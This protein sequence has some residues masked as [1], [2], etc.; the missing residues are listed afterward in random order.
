[1][2]KPHEAFDEKIIE[3]AVDEVMAQYAGVI[4]PAKQEEIRRSLRFGLRTNPHAPLLLR[5]LRP[6]GDVKES[7]TEPILGTAEAPDNVVKGKEGAR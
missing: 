2:T 6:R 1:M 7:G 3:A 4:P 5:R